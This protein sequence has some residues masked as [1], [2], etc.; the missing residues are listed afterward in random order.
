MIHLCITV[1]LTREPLSDS[2][3]H[4]QF[5]EFRHERL[6]GPVSVCNSSHAETH[7]IQNQSLRHDE[8]EETEKTKNCTR[9]I[10]RSISY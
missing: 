6:F 2:S 1:F 5:S 4:V 7:R 9:P 8:K 10:P 3:F